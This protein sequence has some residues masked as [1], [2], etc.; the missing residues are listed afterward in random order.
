MNMKSIIDY[1]EKAVKI[2]PKD[3]VLMVDHKNLIK[4]AVEKELSWNN[5]AC[6]LTDFVLSSD[7]LKDIIKTLVQELETWVSKVE[8]KSDREKIEVFEQFDVI[9]EKEHCSNDTEG[10][11]FV[12]SYE[13]YLEN[14]TSGTQAIEIPQNIENK[15]I[16]DD[17]E[18]KVFETSNQVKILKESKSFTSKMKTN[19]KQPGSKNFECDVFLKSFETKQMTQKHQ[20]AHTGEKP[21]ECKTCNKQFSQSANLK[22]HEKIH[23][24]KKNFECN[25][26]HT[27]FTVKR[28]LMRHQQMH[29][30]EKPYQC[31]FCIKKFSLS[32]NLKLHERHH[33]GEKPFKCSYCK[34]AFA[35]SCDLKKHQRTHTGEKPYQCDLCKM[36]FSLVFSLKRHNKIIHSNKN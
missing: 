29:T 23:M 5:L 26:C 7:K 25:I 14:E 27:S 2:Q 15:N 4:S 6:F 19:V 31:K 11:D 12:E 10:N 20:R 8:N 24:G 34:K 3:G 32:Q 35:Q 1:D 21:Y 17:H 18:S 9:E 33:T 28:S 22:V 36:S 16:H 30:G 13:M